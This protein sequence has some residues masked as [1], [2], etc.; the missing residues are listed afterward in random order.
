MKGLPPLGRIM[1]PDVKATIQQA[2]LAYERE[3]KTMDVQMI[4]EV[5]EMV[6]YTERT[7]SQPG[8]NLLL[9]GRAGAGG[10]EAT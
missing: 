1:T 3:Y 4:D 5:V 10:K 2:L 7:L 6:A 8:A 9:A